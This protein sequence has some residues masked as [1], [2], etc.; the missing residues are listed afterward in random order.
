M[1]PPH[2]IVYVHECMCTC[3]YIYVCLYTHQ[4]LSSC[5]FTV[6]G[7]L[8]HRTF[9][10]SLCE[11]NSHCGQDT[12]VCY[13]DNLGETHDVASFTHQTIMTQGTCMEVTV[14]AKA[15]LVC[16]CL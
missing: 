3:T 14:G 1:F 2:Y 15:V 12:S 16:V 5:R 11:H 7:D 9:H 13:I 8:A 6:E 4:Y 10:V